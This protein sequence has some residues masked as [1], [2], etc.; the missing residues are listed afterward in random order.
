V[1]RSTLVAPA[2]WS[3][4]S[5]PRG[6]RS[7]TLTAT[8]GTSTATAAITGK[9]QG[10]VIVGKEGSGSGTV[11]GP[12]LDCGS[13][14]GSRWPHRASC[15]PR[16]PR[17]DRPSEAGWGVAS[18]PTAV[19]IIAAEHRITARFN[20]QSSLR[21]KVYGTGRVSGPG[22]SCRNDCTFAVD[23]G[24]AIELT[25]SSTMQGHV[26]LG[27]DD[28]CAG[29]PF[30]CSLTMSGDRTVSVYFGDPDA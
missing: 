9:G 8:S 4:R 27:W 24:A 3:R 28:D 23:T 30:T 21:I 16:T 1:D 22:I 7:T 19:P 26:F 17:R 11:T 12:G 25:A 14:V 13:P 6:A 2:P 20:Q 5:G 29:Q 10:V 15:S 18:R